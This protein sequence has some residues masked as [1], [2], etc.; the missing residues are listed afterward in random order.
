LILTKLLNDEKNL[1]SFVK[2]GAISF[3]IIFSFSIMEIFIHQKNVD[4]EN[5]IKQ[6]KEKYIEQN[7]I[8]V[9]NLVNSIYEI[10]NIEK[11]T[12]NENLKKQ[13]KQQVYQAYAIVNSIYNENIK[14]PNYSKEETINLIK[15]A[16]RN[17]R[18][19]NELGYIFIYEMNGTNILNAQFPEIEGK[20]FWE[21]KDSKGISL[22]KEM[23]VI[24]NN[25][26]ETFY[27]WYWRKPYEKDREYKKIGFFKKFEPY[28]I[29]IGT[30]DYLVDYEKQIKEKILHKINSIKFKKPDHIFIYDLKGLCLVNP[31][32]ELIGINR[33]NVKN[34]DGN[35]LLRDMIDYSKK[36]KEGFIRYKA[37]VK[38]NENLKSN[39]KISF[40]KLFEDWG[41]VIGS[42][43]YLEELNAEIE[44]KRLSLEKST[45]KTINK[46]IIISLLITFILILSSFYVSKLIENIFTNYKI[47]IQKEMS[48]VL[49]KEKLLIQQS[50]M[51][52]MGEMIGNIAHQWKQ[53]LNLISLSNG[54]MRMNQDEK[55]FSTKKE[56]DE[57]IDNIDNSVKHL[58]DTIDDFRSFFKPDKEE[59][60]FNLQ[61][62]FDKTCKLINSQFKNNNIKVIKEILNIEL[63]GYQNELLQVLINIFK[64]AKDELIKKGSDENRLLF[65]TTKREKNK[66][67]IKIK[68]NAGGIPR[69]I[70]DKVFKAYFT[71]KNDNEGT[72]IG[73]HMCK[74][75]IEKMHGEILVSNVTYTY[76]GES[77][78]GAEFTISLPKKI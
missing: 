73:L 59:Q 30:G 53:P 62:T 66:I 70:I 27:E 17:I 67:I 12:E 29:F 63:F 47:Q 14:K 21:Y 71:T 16:L 23:N 52:S 45:E 18:F 57:A 58:S 77:Y 15:V 13:I 56:I 11:K 6:L 74:Q 55:D 25:K 39:E 22:L 2:Y 75:I 7:K 28:D 76:K 34:K 44:E 69:D 48:N 37:S 36:N 51:A 20:N 35:H 61:D 38:L 9:E 19:S 5:D 42:G 8:K 50:K 31:K 3:L 46:I 10:I 72:G 24:L 33:Y 4:L 78:A 54:L 32:K 64:N 43:F 68:D 26:D 65:I 40:L 60:Y 41:W 1:T 49:E